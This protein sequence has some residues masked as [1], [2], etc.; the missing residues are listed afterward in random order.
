[1]AMIG[2]GLY[3]RL[4]ARAV[5][6]AGGEPA[7]D[8]WTPEIN[9][10]APGAI[11]DDY[12]PDAVTRINL[13][14]RLARLERLGEIDDFEE[15]LTDRFGALPDPALALLDNAR[16]VTLARSAGVRGVRGGPK[17]VSLTL[18]S[19]SHDRAMQVLAPWREAASSDGDRIM[20]AAVL[21][22]EAARRVMAQHIL[23][24]L[25]A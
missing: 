6:I 9:L 19:R 11:P 14:G 17:G 4:L 8:D 12:V 13:Y 23:Q 22:D 5:K 24:A 25:S 16:L 18:P 21:E 2:A 7:D 15:E 3:Q 20:I 10:G 1:M